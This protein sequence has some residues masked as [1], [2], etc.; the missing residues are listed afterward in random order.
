MSEARHKLATELWYTMRRY[1]VDE[2]FVKTMELIEP[3]SKVIDIGGKKKNKR[4]AFDI[5]KYDLNV[6]YANLDEST[7][8]DYLCDVAEIPVEAGEFDTAIMGELLE[9]L[10]DP[11]PALTEA[12]RVLKKDGVLLITTPFM[13]HEHADPYDFGRYTEYWYKQKLT[14]LGFTDIEV[15]RHGG[16]FSV[17]ANMVKLWAYELNKSGRPKFKPFRWLFHKLAFR[18]VLKAIE[19]DKKEFFD[20]NRYFHG[21]TTGFGVICYKR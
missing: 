10:P 13:F 14:E 18:F 15:H 3:G 21:N 4:G 20:S 11:I 19:L 5:E 9:H 16:F 1:H 6:Q 8:P 7:E 12:Y 2:F 17:L